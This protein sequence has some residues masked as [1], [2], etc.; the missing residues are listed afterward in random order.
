MEA[1]KSKKRNTKSNVV[2]L[3]VG[4][5]LFVQPLVS[6]IQRKS[7]CDEELLGGMNGMVRKLYPCVRNAIKET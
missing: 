3:I 6:R 2:A 4:K 7:H 5:N 1:P